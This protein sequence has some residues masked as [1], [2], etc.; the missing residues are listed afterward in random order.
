MLSK[1]FAENVKRAMGFR[2]ISQSE[3]ARRMGCKPPYVTKLLSGRYSPSIDKA[4]QVADA[5]DV[6]LASLLEKNSEN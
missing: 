4:A 6:S 5:L 3:L 2:H 1:N